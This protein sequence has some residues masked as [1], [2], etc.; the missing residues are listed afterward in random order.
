MKR[1]G[2]A[3]RNGGLR[4]G[5]GSDITQNLSGSATFARSSASSRP[6]AP[7]SGQ[8]SIALA[9]AIGRPSI[10]HG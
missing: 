8:L 3:T 9:A 1:F 2:S 4:E 5:K 7:P 6:A 10:G